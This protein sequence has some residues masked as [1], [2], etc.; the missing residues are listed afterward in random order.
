MSNG[1][2]IA[3]CSA[4]LQQLFQESLVGDD[5]ASALGATPTVSVLPPDR[6]T[7]GA[8]EQPQLNLFMY[9]ATPNLGWAN[10]EL[11]SHDRSGARTTAA[12]LG[13]DLHYMISAYG[14]GNAQAEVLLGHA[15]LVLHAVR[16]LTRE[17]IR[18]LSASTG[19]PGPLLALLTKSGLNDQEEMIRITWEKLSVDE[20]SKL[21]SVF[22]ER[23]RPSMAFAASVLVMRP[24]VQ[25]RLAK[26][27]DVANLRVLPL[28]IARIERVTPA[29]VAIGDTVV[30]EGG[31]LRSTNSV[32]RFG[33]A[34]G[35]DVDLPVDSTATRVEVIV[36][37]GVQAGLSAVQ[38]IHSVDFGP[39]ST[40]LDVADSNVAA[41]IVRP[42]FG[43]A[44]ISAVVDDDITVAMTPEVGRDQKVRVL[45]DGVGPLVGDQVVLVLPSRALDPSPS[46][47]SI[48]FSTDAIDAG[49]YLIRIEVDGVASRL[50]AAPA[51]PGEE[52][53]GHGF[54]GPQVVIP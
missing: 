23:Y 25:A 40:Q 45:L 33:G 4:V 36:P 50:T 53:G 19:V 22:G 37:G 13:L 54:S 30:I 21:W 17:R 1:S 38:I 11:P 27:V 7:I 15:S 28:P 20:I 39:Q 3:A 44:D 16:Y 5:L 29:E 31:G 51:P 8:G 43:Q 49:T 35:A 46:E 12:P 52:E 18:A 10:R 2:A 24:D 34:Q 6:I 42:S 32:V 14:T 9:H 41:L 26:P 48:T 47:P